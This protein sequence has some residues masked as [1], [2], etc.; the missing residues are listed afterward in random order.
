MYREIAARFERAHPGVTVELMPA[1]TY[2]A[3][4]QRD[5]RLALIEDEPDVS[6]VGL[7]QV[8]F[9][10][11]RGLARRLDGLIADSGENALSVHE[12]IGKVAGV[13]HALPFAL[14]V[15]VS[16]FNADLLRRYGRDPDAMPDADWP[17]ILDAA[18]AVS[19]AGRPTSGI[20]FDY[21]PESALAWQMLVLS[22]GGRM[23]SDDERRVAFD[24]PEGH[25]SARL[26][27]ALGNAGQLDLSRE[28]ARMAFAAGQLGCYQNTSANMA[29]FTRTATGFPVLVA[30]LPM[31]PGGTL[32]AAGNAAVIVTRDTARHALAWEYLR[33]ACGPV[34]Q[35]I[36]AKATGYLSLNR[37]A[38]AD[39]RFLKSMVD[40]QPIYRRLQA[41]ADR[42]QGWYAFPGPRSEQIADH[43]QDEMRRLILRR[44]TADHALAMM[45]DATLRLLPR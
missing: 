4:M 8:R 10:A 42:L 9:Y 20:F 33:F 28:N 12:T 40:T 32:P 27:R 14:S 22:R 35:T 34:G 41:I 44:T 6:H 37:A 24:G 38:L 18:S 1:A 2:G 19:R 17:A 30:P 31:A 23:L 15:P 21:T 29:R 43:I 36:M 25:W 16:Y 11:E 13:A 7:N 5:F 26:L 45:R 39:P 3:V